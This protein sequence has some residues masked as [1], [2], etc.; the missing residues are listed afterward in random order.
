M[1]RVG[2]GTQNIVA[3][4]RE[5][6]LSDPQWGINAGVTLT[7]KYGAKTPTPRLNGRQR[8]LLADLEHGDAIRLPI[9]VRNIW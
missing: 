2:R 8:K 6:G 4:C 3:W 5:A 7:L 1:D 9:T